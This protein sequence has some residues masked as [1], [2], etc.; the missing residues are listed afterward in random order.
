MSVDIKLIPASA[1][2]GK[3]YTLKELLLRGLT[4]KA[5]EVD[6]NTPNPRILTEPI[7]PERIVAVTFTEAAA[8]ELKGRIRG[9]LIQQGLHTEAARLDEAYVSTI[10]SFGLRV[11]RESAFDLGL[12]LNPRLL[13]ED[14]EKLLVRKALRHSKQID[15]ITRNL[16]HYGYRYDFNSQTPAEDQLRD[17]LVKLIGLLRSMDSNVNI[18]T[19]VQEARDWLADRYGPV[20]TKSNEQMAKPLHKRVMALLASHPGNMA[21]TYGNSAAARSAFN[22]DFR[23]LKRAQDIEIL[24]T[25]WSLWA[26]L[27][28]LRQSKRGCALPESYDDL[29]QAVMD[30][31]AELHTHPGPLATAQKQVEAMLRSAHETMRLFDADKR[32]AG[33]LD[34]SDMVAN[35]FQALKD[36][37]VAQRVGQR[38]D[39]IFIDEFQDTSPVQFGLLWQLIR[40]GHPSAVVGDRKQSIMGFQGSDIRLFDAMR[41]AY[42]SQVQALGQNWRSQPA[43]LAFINAVAGKLFDDY[44]PLEAKGAAS[45]LP[46]LHIAVMPDEKNCK[47]NSFRAKRI[48]SILS[49]KLLDASCRITDRH[50]GKERTLRGSDIAVLCPTHSMLAE[51]ASQLRK[52]GLKVRLQEDGWLESSEVCMAIEALNLTHNPEDTHAR[53]YLATTAL[54]RHELDEAL[55]KLVQGEALDDPCFAELPALADWAARSQVDAVV[56]EVL[57]RLGIHDAVTHWPDA[58]QARAN[59]LKLEDLAREFVQTQPESLLAS[60]IHG[61]GIPQFVSWLRLYAEQA[62]KGNRKPPANVVDEDAIELVTWHASK[63]REWPIVAVCGMAKTVQAKLPDIKLEYTNYADLDVLLESAHIEYAP[64]FASGEASSRFTSERQPEEEQKVIRELYVA[65]TRPRDQLLLEWPEDAVIGGKI[66]RG[67]LLNDRIGMTLDEDQVVLS[68]GQCFSA[69]VDKQAPEEAQGAADDAVMLATHG[70]R[71]IRKGPYTGSL[72]PDSRAPSGEH[73]SA[74]SVPGEQAWQT[75]KYA[76]PLELPAHEDPLRVGSFV[77]RCFELSDDERARA[78]LVAQAEQLWP[79]RAEEVCALLQTRKAQFEQALQTHLKADNLRT[80][81]PVVGLD[82]NNTVVNGIIDMLADT[83]DGLLI[84]DHKSDRD[85]ELAPIL[86]RHYPQL[87]DYARLLEKTSDKAVICIHAVQF[88]VIAWAQCND[89]VAD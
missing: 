74:E 3:T 4:G 5:W 30:A 29:A 28:E 54:G 40:L 86:E 21:A 62:D 61:K 83:P 75:F 7:R 78:Y 53:L 34:F 20:S 25:D 55:G 46:A 48:A 68:D 89:S 85:A 71:A 24:K 73:A 8:E 14:E 77:H 27:C 63:G 69:I 56:P 82:A 80:E 13:T 72:T 58:R 38:A 66:T 32:E 52:Q 9:A 6:P 2:S 49:A 64:Q 44:H 39:C 35:A 23:A 10:H 41:D 36:P 17:E 79:G 12:A 45:K 76:E 67:F 81:I 59:L 19:L 33:L 70:R 87:A 37:D 26:S 57:R 18:D 42:P 1:G 43:L 60:G 31:A 51:Y 11:L 16:E 88:G 50:T 65:L 47:N 22:S 84:I 15:P